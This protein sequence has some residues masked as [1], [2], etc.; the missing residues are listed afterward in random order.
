MDTAIVA[1]A[2][3][4]TD[5]A[6]EIHLQLPSTV[7]G[8][9]ETPAENELN[10]KLS[11]DKEHQ[12]QNHSNIQEPTPNNESTSKTYNDY[13][14]HMYDDAN[15]KVDEEEIKPLLKS[16]VKSPSGNLRPSLPLNGARSKNNKRLSWQA[17]DPT[18]HH[19]QF[20]H[21]SHDEKDVNTQS[22]S[23][24]SSEEPGTQN[25][26]CPSSPITSSSSSSSSSDDDEEFSEI[27][28]PDGG[29]GWVSVAVTF[30]SNYAIEFSIF[31]GHCVCKFHD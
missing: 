11:S 29:W 27:Q 16:I 3:A 4:D 5:E 31:P 14:N 18:R 26:E 19:V 13:V 10:L 17:A 9:H 30:S 2:A 1:S 24:D 15:G 7:N 23:L 20:N 28:A 12:N 25:E 21:Q 22:T 6:N 8:E